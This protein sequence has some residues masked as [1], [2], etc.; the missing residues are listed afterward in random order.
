MNRASLPPATTRCS[1]P[2]TIARSPGLGRGRCAAGRCL[3]RRHPHRAGSASRRE[4]LRAVDEDRPA[5]HD[6]TGTVT[7]GVLY[8][9]SMVADRNALLAIGG[10]DERPRAPRRGR[11][12]RPLLPVARRPGGRFRYEPDLVVWH[13]DWRDAEQLVRTQPC[14]ARA[15][16]RRSYAKHLH[17]RR[18]P[19]AADAGVGPAPRPAQRGRRGS[20]R[21]PPLAGP[22]PGDG[23]R[24]CS[25]GCVA[26]GGR[27]RRARLARPGA[28]ASL[29][30]VAEQPAQEDAARVDGRT[31]AAWRRRAA[32]CSARRRRPP[33]C[34]DTSRPARSAARETTISERRPADAEPAKERRGGG[35]GPDGEQA[36]RCVC[37]V[38]RRGERRCGRSR[39]G[40]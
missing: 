26:A 34:H 10:F 2:T 16:G 27:Q 11:G 21:A 28:W 38:R 25:S 17:G 35:G 8:P 4:R 39:A 14:Y 9:A 23:R 32:R 19:G 31:P 37:G 40:G 33:G 3:T 30:P 6:Y 1:S 36:G 20:R 13:H 5:P 24:R 15:Q 18:P 22:L 12:Q 7:A 29:V